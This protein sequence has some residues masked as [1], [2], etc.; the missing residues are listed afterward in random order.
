MRND[1]IYHPRRH[2]AMAFNQAGRLQNEAVPVKEFLIC[3]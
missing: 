2:N 1:M 3:G